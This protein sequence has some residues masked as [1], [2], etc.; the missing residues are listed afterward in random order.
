MTCTVQKQAGSSRANLVEGRDDQTDMLD[1]STA[2][3]DSATT[4][5]DSHAR[6]EW[7]APGSM[8][9]RLIGPPLVPQLDGLSRREEER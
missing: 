8:A 6:K 7:D 4:R 2:R 1:R 3:K 9:A 5:G